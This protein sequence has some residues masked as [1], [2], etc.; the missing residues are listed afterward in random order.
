[1]ISRDGLSWKQDIPIVF[2]GLR[3]E[4]K[5]SEELSLE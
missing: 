2:T 3:P 1:M 5:L 4:E